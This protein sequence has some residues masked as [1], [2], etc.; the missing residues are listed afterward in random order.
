MRL[1]RTERSQLDR[2]IRLV[3]NKMSIYKVP[4]QN[5]TF[6]IPDDGEVFR[7]GDSVG[8]MR[9]NTI[10]WLKG[11]IYGQEAKQLPP[12][13]L[14]NAHNY[15]E[16][17]LHAITNNGSYGGIAQNGGETSDL[18]LFSGQQVTPG[19][20][21]TQTVDPNN[22]NAAIVKTEVADLPAGRQA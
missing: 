6:P 4:G 10:Y 22:Q 20:N 2:V 11:G 7:W 3:S 15:T 21:Y 19:E 5:L 14:N 16:G 13:V 9:G 12:G 17:G 18:S 1:I 8:V